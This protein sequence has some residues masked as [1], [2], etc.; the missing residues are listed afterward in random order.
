MKNIF[1]AMSIGVAVALVA[2]FGI[3][4][5]PVVKAKSF[6]AQVVQ[7]VEPAP[8]IITDGFYRFELPAED[9]STIKLADFA[10]KVVLVVNTAAQCFFASQY[11]EL[12]E[13]YQKYKEQG[14]V[15][16]GVSSDDFG[17]EI[18]DVE[19]RTCSI[20][21]HITLTFIMADTVHVTG[22]DAHPLFAWLNKKAG[23]MGSVKWNFHKF[24]IG[25]D[26][27]FIDWFAPNTGPHMKKVIKAIEKALAA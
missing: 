9:G 2:S 7:V 15:I 21:G 20:E 1:V 17:Q 16:I 23:A 18:E 8:K 11:K 4:Y 19:A 13:L 5:N 6:A 24:L 27:E 22:K 10:G 12:E 26:G 25:R 3:F 14:L